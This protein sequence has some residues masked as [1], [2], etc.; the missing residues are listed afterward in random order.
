MAGA[1]A[2]YRLNGYDVSAYRGQRVQIV[3]S[4]APPST[5]GATAAAGTTP[6]GAAGVAVRRDFI[7]Q[8]VTPGAGTCPQR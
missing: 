7:V 6:S 5:P 3:G 2:G 1:T 8:S 4:F